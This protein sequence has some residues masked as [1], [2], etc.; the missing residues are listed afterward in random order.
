MKIKLSK[1]IYFDSLLKKF[2][3]KGFKNEL[4]D[5]MN[6]EIAKSSRKYIRDGRVSPALEPIT[7]KTRKNKGPEPL[8]DTGA[9]ARSIKPTKKGIKYLDYGNFHRQGDGVPRREFISIRA[10]S[11]EKNKITSKVARRLAKLIKQNVGK[12]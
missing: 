1:Y 2:E 6:D 9:L 3:Q 7:I 11:A 4:K 8:L 10:N 5:F 12:K